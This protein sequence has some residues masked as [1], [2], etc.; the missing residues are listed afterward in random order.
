MAEPVPDADANPYAP[1]TR[2]CAV[3]RAPMEASVYGVYGPYRTK[4]R[5]GAHVKRLQDAGIYRDMEWDIQPLRL[6]D[7]GHDDA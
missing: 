4:A 6:I 3:V 7:L 2:W 1:G 5:A